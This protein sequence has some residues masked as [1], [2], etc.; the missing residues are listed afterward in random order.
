M[1]NMYDI[2]LK[3]VKNGKKFFMVFFVVGILFGVILLGVFAGTML[4]GNSLD[5]ETMST[6][7]DLNEYYDDGDIMYKPVYTYEV[8]GKEYTCSSGIS[9][10]VRPSSKNIKVYYD[11]KN[12]SKCLTDYSKNSSYFL[13]LFLI[14]PIVFI[15]MSVVN[16]KKIN[17][18][19][20]TIN[21]LNENGKLVKGLPYRL[22]N[23]GMV[24]NNVPIQRPVIDYA[25]ANGSIIQL[26]GDPRHDRKVADQDG[27]VDLVID[28]SNPEN[29]FIDF[30]INRVGGNRPE[31]FYQQPNINPNGLDQYGYQTNNQLLNFEQTNSFD[32]T[33]QF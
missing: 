24:V 12:P 17:K 4:K 13:L 31:D 19:I 27:L 8:D 20:A 3:N 9:S 10:S 7:V 32:Q 33:Q 16:F 23:T 11:S 22:E 28:E 5:S 6:K 2:N 1:F 18:R 21:S 15:V 26:Y 29:Y 30:E 14:I 25:L